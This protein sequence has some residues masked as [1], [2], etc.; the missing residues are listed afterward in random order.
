ML[1][2]LFG[3]KPKPQSGTGGRDGDQPDVF[4]RIGARAIAASHSANG[5]ILLYAEVAEGVI[6]ADLFS[7]SSD[8]P[9][10][11]R[12]SPPELKALIYEWWEGLPAS[13]RW[14]TMAFSI[15]GGRFTCSFG[16][17]DVLLAEEHLEDRR[18]RAV[19]THFGDTAVDYSS[20]R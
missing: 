14:A 20:P 10:R 15:D 1:S 18:P 16:Y 11:F 17:P 19:Q 8:E 4:Q 6:S 13:E 12:F 9:V 7:Q 3:Q 2:K 5:K